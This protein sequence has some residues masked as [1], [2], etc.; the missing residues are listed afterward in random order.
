M[1]KT[2]EKNEES[3]LAVD[4]DE[5]ITCISPAC[6]EVL[7]IKTDPSGHKLDEVLGQ[8]SEVVAKCREI[9]G[10]PDD[11][12]PVN[13]RVPLPGGKSKKLLS[14]LYPLKRDGEIMGIV[15]TFKDTKRIASDRM[16]IS[17]TERLNILF[18][19]VDSLA[20]E[21]RN[22]LNA[23]VINL[24]VLK[25]TIRKLPPE[26]L[27][28][29]NGYIKILSD[30]LERVR[31]I[32]DKFL[33][34]ANPVEVVHTDIE[35]NHIIDEVLSLMRHQA[36]RSHIKIFKNLNDI[37][38]YVKGEADQ[39]KQV[40]IN[41]ILNAIE[42]MPEGGK[43]TINTRKEFGLAIIEVID[44]GVGIPEGIQ[45]YIFD[46]YFTTKEKG[47]GLGLSIVAR[48][49]EFHNGG[50][51]LESVEGK[52]TKFTVELPLSEYEEA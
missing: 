34:L 37:P 7:R 46:L 10:K 12:Y 26:S 27:Q 51:D 30:E 1:R 29:A 2:V 22:P 21:I 39:L 48:I 19:L 35:L 40:A 43:L 24:E 49:L 18:Q 41:L 47:M 36:E 45:D 23:I 32:L 6:I 3:F 17:R 9:F 38:I 4:L 44:T 14:S 8:N 33:G 11:D 50:I 20:H 5:R 13:L 52:G 15:I 28:R 16:L 25:N 42:A 31:N